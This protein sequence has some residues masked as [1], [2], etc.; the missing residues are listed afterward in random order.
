MNDE[1]L[2][3]TEMKFK[4]MVSRRPWE[5]EP[6][7]AEWVDESTGYT[8][9]IHRHQTLGHLNGYVTLPRGHKLDDVGYDFIEVNVH[10]GL[11]YADRDKNS[12]GWVLGFDCSHAGDFSPRLAMNL[13]K[14]MGNHDMDFSLRTEV[15]REWAWVEAEV[16]S[17]ARQLKEQE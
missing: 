10:G 5:S 16:L 13:L 2:L 12:G 7:V 15:Y 11:T 9:R 3:T 8:C 4:L 6:D 1:D 17:L 14:Y